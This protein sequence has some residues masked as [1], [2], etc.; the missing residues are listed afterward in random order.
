M[1]GA[2]RTLASGEGRCMVSPIPDLLTAED[3]LRL[4]GEG[5]D[6]DLIRGV[7][8]QTT[9]SG[10][11]RRGVAIANLGFA[12]YGFAKSRGL[13]TALMGR[14][15]ILLERDPDTVLGAH[16][17]YFA[18]GRLSSDNNTGY[19]EVAPDLVVDIFSPRDCF[20]ELGDK[21]RM[22]LGFGVRLV[23]VGYPDSRS[24]EVF[25]ADGS[26]ETLGIG[27]SLDGGD[28]IPG[29]SCAVGEGFD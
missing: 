23:W 9:R 18:A 7:F 15:G 28:V 26:V 4:D 27:D 24:I 21:A 6:G 1:N 2:I 25:R 5:V 13:G 17:V 20:Q 10:S 16:L 11:L 19:A 3:L 14:P 8:R 29:F 22:W 12:L